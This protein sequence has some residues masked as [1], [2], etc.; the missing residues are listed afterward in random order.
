MQ[1]KSIIVS[2]GMLF[3]IVF[4]AFNTKDRDRDR[5]EKFLLS[6]SESIPNHSEEELKNIPKPEHPHMATFQ[7]KFMTIDPE[8]GYVPSE[9]L[10]RAFLEKQAIDTENNSRTISWQN[11]PTNMGGRTRTIICNYSCN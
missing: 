8:L 11:I 3:F 4:I 9:R 5:Y 10:Y 2:V 6:K 1:I 7:N